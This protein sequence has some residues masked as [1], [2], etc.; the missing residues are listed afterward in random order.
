MYKSKILTVLHSFLI[1]QLNKNL[2]DSG[3]AGMSKTEE[4][5]ENN[6]KSKVVHFDWKFY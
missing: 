5:G 6:Q 4:D 3:I 1:A 2:R